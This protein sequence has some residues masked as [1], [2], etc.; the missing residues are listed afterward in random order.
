MC[1]WYVCACVCT[2]MEYE[3]CTYPPSAQALLR[4]G[5]DTERHS[6]PVGQG[7]HDTALPMLWYP[8]GQPS[9]SFCS[10]K[11]LFV[12]LCFVLTLYLMGSGFKLPYMYM[13]VHCI[14]V[15]NTFLH[16]NFPHLEHNFLRLS[17]HL[18][19]RTQYY[20]DFR[21]CPD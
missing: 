10:K 16:G 2:R 17:G 18:S 15:H 5:S 14:P 4:L 12:C 20:W 7:S 3:C 6:N 21:N 19:L 13:C 9:G 11:C 8:R 1:V